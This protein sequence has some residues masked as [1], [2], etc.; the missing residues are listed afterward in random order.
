MK[1]FDAFVADSVAVS[2]DVNS[3]FESETI[4]VFNSNA[5]TT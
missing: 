4:F 5:R 2:I 1:A 3:S